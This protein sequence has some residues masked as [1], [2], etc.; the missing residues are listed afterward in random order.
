MLIHLTSNSQFPTNYS[1]PGAWKA[2]NS[3]VLLSSWVGNS[4]LTTRIF[5]KFWASQLLKTGSAA[6][7]SACVLFRGVYFRKT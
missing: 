6:L 5:L 2:V 3:H 4:I 1:G 7:C